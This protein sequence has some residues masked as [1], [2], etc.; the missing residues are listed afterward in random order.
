MLKENKRNFIEFENKLKQRFLHSLE[1]T[2]EI[3]AWKEEILT[4][5]RRF[6]EENNDVEAA[7][8]LL[9]R[10]EEKRLGEMG[11]E[12]KEKIEYVMSQTSAM[13]QNYLSNYK[14]ELGNYLHDSP[15]SIFNPRMDLESVLFNIEPD[16]NEFDFTDPHRF[17]TDTEKE[18][19]DETLKITK[20]P[21]ANFQ[22]IPGIDRN[23]IFRKEQ[24]TGNDDL[25]MEIDVT[26]QP[27]FSPQKKKTKE[28]LYPVQNTLLPPQ[29]VRKKKSPKPLQKLYSCKKLPEYEK[30]NSPRSNRN[31]FASPQ[32][33][34]KQQSLQNL[35]VGL[36]RRT[37][38]N[39]S[40]QLMPAKMEKLRSRSKKSKRSEKEKSDTELKSLL[41]G[42]YRE[43]VM[44]LRRNKLANLDLS[45]GGT[46]K[47]LKRLPDN[48]FM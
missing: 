1:F 37:L 40:G 35:N 4:L 17:T 44:D 23:D 11:K 34:V 20:A 12:F 48:L 33:M 22:K 5:T 29:S 21:H 6:K 45:F 38:Q 43:V 13:M 14:A 46:L 19:L 25:L 18:A 16:N 3:E 30:I 39:N 10:E 26:D 47:R 27:G 28:I 41:K 42:R 24:K 31:N 7:F 15:I 2:E 8:D 32:P 36:R 9:T